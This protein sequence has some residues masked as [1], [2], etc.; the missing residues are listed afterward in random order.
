MRTIGTLQARPSF[1]WRGA[2]PLL[3]CVAALGL[4]TVS[5]GSTP[6]APSSG[7]T[8]GGSSPGAGGSSSGA[9]AGSSPNGGSTSPAGGASNGGGGQSGGG[10][11][12]GPAGGAGSGGLVGSAGAIGNAGSSGSGGTSGSGGAQANGGAAGALAGNG[13]D[14]VTAKFC[15]DFEKQ[16]SGQAPVGDFKV[17]A[18]AGAMIV[19]GSKPHGG[20]QSLHIKMAKPGTRAM[21]DFT[22]QFPFNDLHGRAMIATGIEQICAARD[23]LKARIGNDAVIFPMDQLIRAIAPR[24]PKSREGTHIDLGQLDG[25]SAAFTQSACDSIKRRLTEQ[26][27]V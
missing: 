23:D 27:F 22:K 17:S 16:T 26:S 7:E 5:C 12:A 6:P 1:A 8:N 20:K 11:G 4:G 13:C 9:V 19:D 24:Y 3:S 10:S 18:S 14:G 25:Q 15:D 2:L 21:L